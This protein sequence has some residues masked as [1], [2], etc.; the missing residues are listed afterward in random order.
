MVLCSSFLDLFLNL[1]LSIHK[2]IKWSEQL[3]ELK[4][5]TKQLRKIQNKPE[6]LKQDI[7]NETIT[8]PD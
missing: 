3:E 5:T 2:L 4:E 6:V 8:K 1:I 7:V